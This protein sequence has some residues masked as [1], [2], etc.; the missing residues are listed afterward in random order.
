VAR[1]VLLA[2]AF[3]SG[4]GNVLT[5]GS[6]GGRSYA[7]LIE[8]AG[9]EVLQ[10]YVVTGSYDVVMIV[11]FADD[12]APLAFS[13]RSAA[14]G[15]YVEALRAYGDA[16]VDTARSRFPDVEE[17]RRVLEEGAKSAGEG[18]EP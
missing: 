8:Q 18:Q 4:A 16:E 1:Y 7:E 12:V 3:E 10:R 15:L 13:L 11:D 2:R 17:A 14:G 5:W 9:G 6:D